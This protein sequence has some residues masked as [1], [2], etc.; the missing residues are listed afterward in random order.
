MF[1]VVPAMSKPDRNSTRRS[2]RPQTEQLYH[3]GLTS[4]VV[5]RP[6]A[7]LHTRGMARLESLV[8]VVQ[9]C[10][11]FGQPIQR[12]AEKCRSIQLALPF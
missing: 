2:A 9:T 5:G 1:C 6:S 12:G 11:R 8:L 7:P 4:V 10:N 3:T